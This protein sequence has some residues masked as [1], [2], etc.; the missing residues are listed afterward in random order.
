MSITVLLPI[1]NGA[2][3][4]AQAVDSILRQSH[5]DFELLLIDDA[6]TDGSDAIVRAYARRDPRVTGVVHERNVGLART[7]NEGLE[8]AQFEL[9]AR[10]DQDDE[11]L[12][13]RLRVQKAFLEAHREIAVAGSW[14]LHM[15]AHPKFD[16]LVRLPTSHQEIATTLPR[17][18]CLYHPSVMLRRSVVVDAGGYRSEFKNAEDY[19]LWLRL[20]RTHEL[21]NVPRPLIRYRFSVGGMTLGRKWEQLFYV[22]FAQAAAADPDLTLAEAEEQARSTLAGVNRSRFL[23]DVARGTVRE[24]VALRL[25]HDAAAVAMRFHKEIGFRASISLLAGIG[26]ARIVGGELV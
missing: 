24:L 3:T 11:A 10:L 4:L 25:W 16:R 17:E 15:G 19:D 14:V 1:Y 12:P 26:R 13:E 2:R 7:L 5:G 21:A 8:R 23:M 22:H 18:N 20:A 9:V 6:S